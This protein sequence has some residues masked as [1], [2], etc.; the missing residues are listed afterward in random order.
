MP[1]EILSRVPN[2]PSP[3]PA[4]VE[5]IW[6]TSLWWDKNVCLITSSNWRP[7]HAV[8]LSKIKKLWTTGRPFQWSDGRIKL[9]QRVGLLLKNYK[10]I[11]SPTSFIAHHHGL[12]HKLDISC[13]KTI[14]QVIITPLGRRESVGVQQGIIALICLLFVSWALNTI[15]IWVRLQC[16]QEGVLII[17]NRSSKGMGGWLLTFA[18]I[19]RRNPRSCHMTHYQRAVGLA[20]SSF[21]E[22]V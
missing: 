17:F 12:L 6:T 10:H 4:W 21:K 2:W 1:P 5:N 11:T 7:L 3:A 20:A 14:K 9:Q 13:K 18:G 8:R 22:I 16:T 15:L 19:V